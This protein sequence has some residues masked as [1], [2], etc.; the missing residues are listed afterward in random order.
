MISEEE[1]EHEFL[2]SLKVHIAFS[3]IYMALTGVAI[4]MA[5]SSRRRSGVRDMQ[6]LLLMLAGLVSFFLYVEAESGD[7]ILAH[8]S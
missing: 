7:P 4:F 5:L 2:T 6:W 1:F 3:A 8:C